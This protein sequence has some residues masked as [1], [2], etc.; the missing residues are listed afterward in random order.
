M[1]VAVVA[2]VAVVVVVVVVVVASTRGANVVCFDHVDFDA[3]FAPQWRAFFRHLNFKKCSG[4]A[5]F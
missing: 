4:T 3:C 1:V 2:V 5:S